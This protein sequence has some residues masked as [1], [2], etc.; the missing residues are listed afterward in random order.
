MLLEFFHVYVTLVI[1][2]GDTRP[3]AE[4]DLVGS[5]AFAEIELA[6]SAALTVSAFFCTAKDCVTLVAAI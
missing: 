6:D 1:V 3:D 2:F 4:K 5:V